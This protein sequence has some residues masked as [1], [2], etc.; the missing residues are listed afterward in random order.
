M[1]DAEA[2]AELVEGLAETLPFVHLIRTAPEAKHAYDELMAR[3]ES[4]VLVFNRPP[5][6][7]DPGDVNPAVLETLARDVKIR[8]LYQA[9]P[10]QDPGAEAFRRTL[11]ALDEAGVQGR[12]VPDLPIQLAIFDRKISLL[13]ISDPILPESNFRTIV[14]IEHPGF[15]AVQAYA[16]EQLWAAAR[17]YRRARSR[18]RAVAAVAEA[19]DEGP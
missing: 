15:S 10:L 1:D 12:V 19:P 11:E 18:A 5:Y 16:F 4:E 13:A 7:I 3:A 17:P 6:S 2:D 8:A 14:L 9:A